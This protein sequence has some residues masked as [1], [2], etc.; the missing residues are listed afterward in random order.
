MTR[1]LSSSLVCF[2]DDTKTS[3]TTFRCQGFGFLETARFSSKYVAEKI[4][5]KLS[6]KEASKGHLKAQLMGFGQTLIEKTC[7]G[8]AAQRQSTRQE[9]MR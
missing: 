1:C 8:V 6:V 3:E 2:M 7:V 9:I 4:Q 5:F